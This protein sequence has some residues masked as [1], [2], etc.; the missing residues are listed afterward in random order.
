[1]GKEITVEL[2]KGKFR[3]VTPVVEES[4]I[5]EEGR[6]ALKNL[7]DICLEILDVKHKK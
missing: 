3:V 4:S 1:M 6:K 5:K 2:I 7:A